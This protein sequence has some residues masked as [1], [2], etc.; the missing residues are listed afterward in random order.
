M[1]MF[2]NTGVNGAFLCRLIITGVYGA[3]LKR[4]IIINYVLMVCFYGLLWCIINT[5]VNIT[6]RYYGV[7]LIKVFMLPY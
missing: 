2:F 4:V 5:D 3:L 1:T 7:L 6:V